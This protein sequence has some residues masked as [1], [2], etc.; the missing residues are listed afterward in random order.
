VR[1]DS[2]AYT[3]CFVHPYYDSLLAKLIVHGRNREEALSRMSRALE[4]FIVE[5]V[6]TSIPLHRKILDDPDFLRGDY[7]LQFLERYQSRLVLAAK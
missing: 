6:Q 7:N 4:M 1:V 3:E 5:G 2:A